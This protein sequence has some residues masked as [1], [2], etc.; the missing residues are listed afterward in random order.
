[1]LIVTENI[2][3]TVLP[4]GISAMFFITVSPDSGAPVVTTLAA[5]FALG[6]ICFSAGASAA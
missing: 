6:E 3:E 1:M 2:I 5:L 4:G